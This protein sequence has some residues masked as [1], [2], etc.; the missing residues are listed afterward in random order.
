MIKI[1]VDDNWFELTKDINEMQLLIGE[2]DIQDVKGLHSLKPNNLEMIYS[3]QAIVS[4]IAAHNRK[5]FCAF[6][7]LYYDSPQLNLNVLSL[8][9]V[10]A[11]VGKF[12]SKLDFLS[13]FL[14]KQNVPEDMV[15]FLDVEALL[16]E[17]FTRVFDG[18]Q[19]GDFLY[20]FQN[21]MLSKLGKDFGAVSLQ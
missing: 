2:R 7:T 3:V 20:V 15:K 18:L 13:Y 21:N 12:H 8:V 5:Q 19:H 6:L 17:L 16:N 10:H 11:Y 4:K 1:K 14:Q 9:F